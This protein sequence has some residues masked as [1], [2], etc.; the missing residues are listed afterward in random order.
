MV[1]LGTMGVE[2]GEGEDITTVGTTGVTG[3]LGK[4]SGTPV[5]TSTKRG[6]VDG[7]ERWVEA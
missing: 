5:G 7:P 3:G 6:S 1:A 2:L 4:L